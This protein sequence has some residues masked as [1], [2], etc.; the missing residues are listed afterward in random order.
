MVYILNRV[1]LAVFG[2]KDENVCMRQPTLLKLNDID[3][4]NRAFQNMVLVNIIDQLL[5][6]DFEHSSYQ[7]RSILRLLSEQQRSLDFKPLG[8]ASECNKRIRTTGPSA[9][10][11][12]I[13][14]ILNHVTWIYYERRW[15]NDPLFD[16]NSANVTCSDGVLKALIKIRTKFFLIQAQILQA[17]L[18][19]SCISIHNVLLPQSATPKQ[20][21]AIGVSML[22]S[23][24]VKFRH[25]HIA[26]L[27]FK[28]RFFH[29]VFIQICISN[30][31]IEL[32]IWMPS[33][34]TVRK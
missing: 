1:W 21:N 19:D 2:K 27:S 16:G 33:I 28:L 32:N 12:G 34:F 11:H 24:T 17:I 5:Q 31:T 26:M 23:I 10:Y 25:C 7:I 30:N 3:S 6:L 14:I 22:K 4:H 8:I 15:Q 9:D 13:L 18:F 20:R 29:M